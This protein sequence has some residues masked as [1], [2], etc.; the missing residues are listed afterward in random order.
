MTSIKTSER[1]SQ[2]R[3]EIRG[4]LVRRLPLRNHFRATLLP[5]ASTSRETAVVHEA[6]VRIDRALDRHAP[7][8][9]DPSYAVEAPDA[10][11]SAV[12]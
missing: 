7:R 9:S 11:T 3:Y 8:Q 12:A 4:E 6:L 2:C 1:L 10:H 5:E